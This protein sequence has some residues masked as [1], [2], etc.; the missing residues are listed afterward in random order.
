MKEF[1]FNIKKHLVVYVVAIVVIPLGVLAGVELKTKTPNK[2]IFTMFIATDEVDREEIVNTLGQTLINDGITEM[3][4][5]NDSPVKDELMFSDSLD[6]KGVGMSDIMLLPESVTNESF[7]ASTCLAFTSYYEGGLNYGEDN[8]VTYGVKV[9]DKDA[10]T[11]NLSNIFNFELADENYYIVIGKN[12]YH[13]SAYSNDK[14]TILKDAINWFVNYE[15]A[16]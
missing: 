10:K 1:W 14:N 12:S 5:F 16:A 13:Y 4:F 3:R 9:Y 8:N 7:L 2:E 11:S 6:G 15:K